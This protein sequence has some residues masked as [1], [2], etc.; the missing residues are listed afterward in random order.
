MLAYSLVAI[1]LLLA[2]ACGHNDAR[3]EMQQKYDAM[4]NAVKARKADA[5][6]VLLTP[7]FQQVGADKKTINRASME[8][9][10]RSL[11]KEATDIDSKSTVT[12]A[13]SD[14]T[15]AD[16]TVTTVQKITMKEPT[17]DK[18]HLI[19]ITSTSNDVWTKDGND[20]KLAQSTETEHKATRDGQPMEPKK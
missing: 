9:V 5:F 15:R 6:L 8:E 3:A 13:T 12:R 7:T 1:A 4:D 20:W 19:E 10:T 17:S 11:F 18:T 14:G 2:S 16:V